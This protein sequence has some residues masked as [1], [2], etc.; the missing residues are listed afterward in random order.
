MN[1]VKLIAATDAISIC[2]GPRGKN[3]GTVFN[4]SAGLRGVSISAGKLDLESFDFRAVFERG[5]W[6]SW[7]PSKSWNIGL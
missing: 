3:I 7:R 5:V 2:D 6:N 1:N 4:G